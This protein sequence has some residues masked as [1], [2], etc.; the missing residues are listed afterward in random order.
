MVKRVG[1]P[2]AAGGGQGER[3]LGLYI[4]HGDLAADNLLGQ[5]QQPRFGVRKSWGRGLVEKL[6]TERVVA[7]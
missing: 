1:C 6:A 3:E 4:R 2:R 7:V 5:G